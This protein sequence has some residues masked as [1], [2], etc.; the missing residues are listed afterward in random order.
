MMTPIL[1]FCEQRDGHLKK[2]GLEALG[3]A[4]RMGKVSSRAV[5]ALIV[6]SSVGSLTQDLTS[7]GASRIL[8]AEDPALTYYSSE[9]FTM[10]VADIATRLKPVAIL[11]GTTAMG[12][13][14]LWR[15]TAG[16]CEGDEPADADRDAS[17]ERVLSCSIHAGTRSYR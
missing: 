10:I 16:G 7:H 17:P 2:V 12:R 11:M 8:I 1:V 9:L 5:V 3:Q 4:C 6:G 15:E 13:D 14:D